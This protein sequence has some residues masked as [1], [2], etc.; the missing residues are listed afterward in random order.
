MDLITV[1]RA[2]AGELQVVEPGSAPAEAAPHWY[3]QRHGMARAGFITFWGGIVLAALFGIVGDAVGNVDNSLGTLLVN[4]AG[5]GALVVLIGIGMMFYSLFLSKA[6]AYPLPPQQPRLPNP[7]SQA[8]FPQEGYRQPISSVTEPTTKLF[9]EADPRTQAR[10][11][12][13]RSE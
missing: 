4:L 7:G 2:L 9:D 11:R 12:T 5:L 10:D 3:N 6:P 13:G 1:S 8:Q